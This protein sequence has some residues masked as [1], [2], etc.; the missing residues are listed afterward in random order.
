MFDDLG[1]GSKVLLGVAVAVALK[2][3]VVW[4]ITESRRRKFEK[5]GY[6]AELICYPIKSCKG[7]YVK[8]AECAKRGLKV[9]GVTDR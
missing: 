9:K 1:T 4:W 3:T 5:V 2:Y 8:E 6:V 7:V